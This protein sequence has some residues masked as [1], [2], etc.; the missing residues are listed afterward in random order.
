MSY[1]K[2]NRSEVISLR[3]SL[4]EK[5]H[6][7]NLADQDGLNIGTYIRN[8][9]FDDELINTDKESNDAIQRSVNEIQRLQIISSK[10]AMKIAQTV[11]GQDN[12][13]ECQKEIAQNLREKGYE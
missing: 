1:I 9:L 7:Q 2:S 13:R 10:L 12:F 3:L 4:P 8:R 11:L 5:T 6:I